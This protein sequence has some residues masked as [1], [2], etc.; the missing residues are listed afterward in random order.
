MS[1][2][3]RTFRS[4]RPLLR[5]LVLASLAV[6]LLAA[7]GGSGGSGTGAA[8]LNLGITDGPIDGA[9]SVVI[10]VTGVELQRAGGGKAITF[11]F[12]S[13]MSVDLLQ[14]QNGKASGLLNGASVP[15][16]NYQWIR[17]LLNVAQDGTVANSYIM[18]NGG[19]YPLVIP[20]GAQT[21]LKLVQGFTL[22]A[23][24]TAN[25]TIDFM[26]AQSISATAPPGQTATH[27]TGLQQAYF[28]V[29][30]M[31]LLNNAQVGTISGTVAPTS[32]QTA[33]AATCGYSTSTTGSLPDAHVYIYYGQNAT[34]TDV[35]NPPP[36][37]HINP[38]VAS[39]TYSSS[40]DEYTFD[41]PFLQTGDYTVALVC[42][43]DNPTLSDA[44]GLAF[45]GQNGQTT[46]TGVPVTVTANQTATVTF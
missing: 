18:I 13:P 6:P 20:S 36:A 12:T 40:L 25:Y 22:T 39:L 29:P 1:P 8:V 17:L 35:V 27:L 14:D 30:A 34:L 4:G 10:S 31:R 45:L 5:L 3:T 23:N 38:V 43:T 11:N 9:A 21:G 37:G 26:L 24:Q 41:Q 46:T 32:L 44:T 28:L 16:G 7:C 33:A 15:A 42:G 2:M 19:Q